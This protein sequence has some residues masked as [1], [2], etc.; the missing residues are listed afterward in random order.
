MV[1]F[2]TNIASITDQITGFSVSSFLQIFGG[3]VGLSLLDWKLTMFILLVIPV[4]YGIVNSFAKKKNI[5]MEQWIEN[6]CL[7]SAWF[8]DCIN[9]IREM[10]LWNLFYSKQEKFEELQKKILNSYQDNLILDQYTTLSVSV[11]DGLGIFFSNE[12]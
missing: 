3:L 2:F 11:V 10:K 1:N 12:R 4:K 5:L 9:G 6:S 8:G 7:F